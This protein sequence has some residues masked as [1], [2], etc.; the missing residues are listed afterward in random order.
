MKMKNASFFKDDLRSFA[1][2]YGLLLLIFAF[3]S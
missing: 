3:K 1:A 2:N